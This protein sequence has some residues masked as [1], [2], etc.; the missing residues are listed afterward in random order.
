MVLGKL[1]QEKQQ[2]TVK[3]KIGFLIGVQH[4]QSA[5][6]RRLI[7]SPF[8][9]SAVFV[10]VLISI[11]F[12]LAPL[13]SLGQSTQQYICS[14]GVKASQPCIICGSMQAES[15]I[16]QLANTGEG[17]FCHDL[18]HHLQGVLVHQ[19]GVNWSL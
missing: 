18:Q 5:S 19:H 2:Y 12:S 14:C 7:H 9:Q 15:G 1:F 4:I 17:Q 8:D 3:K 10:L 16:M 6:R 13:G 11:P